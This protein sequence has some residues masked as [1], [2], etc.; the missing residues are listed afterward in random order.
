MQCL[1]GRDFCGQSTG[2]LRWGSA[3]SVLKT[4]L[5]VTPRWMLH[6]RMVGNHWYS[7]SEPANGFVADGVFVSEEKWQRG[8]INAIFHISFAGGRWPS[9]ARRLPPAYDQLSYFSCLLSQW[10]RTWMSVFLRE[11]TRNHETAVCCYC[12]IKNQI[13]VGE[14]ISFL[15]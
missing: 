9:A 8:S 6:F 14:H 11:C 5:E 4:V 12:I 15:I 2:R 3:A 10:K 1:A 7:D 13:A